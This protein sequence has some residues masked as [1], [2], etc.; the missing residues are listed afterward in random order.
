VPFEALDLVDAGGNPPA[1]GALLSRMTVCDGAQPAYQLQVGTGQPFQ[2]QIDDLAPGGSTLSLS[3][4]T[5]ATYKVLRPQF[6]LAVSPQDVGFTAAAVVNAATFTPGLSPGGLVSIFGVGLAGTGTA[7][8]VDMDGTAMALLLATP[9]QINAQVPPAMAT[10][11]RTIHVSSA[12]GSAQQQVTVSAVSPGI[13]I[14]GNPPVGAM[15]NANYSLIQPSNPLPRGQ[16][17]VIY[18]TGLGAVTQKAQLSYT[19]AAVTVVLNGTELPASFA[20]LAPGFTGLYQVN[21]TIPVATPPG[22]AIPMTLKVGGVQ[23]NS[24]MLSVQ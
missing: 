1:A 19:N 3:G 12:F 22:L 11:V 18:A 20:G 7:T 10:G 13:F 14:V 17:L 8:K 5:A 6:Y 9:F 2:A 21:V 16:V 15:T 23:S 4:N 24:V